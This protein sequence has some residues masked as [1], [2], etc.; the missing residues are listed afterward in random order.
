MA[1]NSLSNAEAF[2]VAPEVQMGVQL[3]IQKGWDRSLC[4]ETYL[5]ALTSSEALQHYF[6]VLGSCVAVSFDG[7]LR[8][9]LNDVRERRWMAPEADDAERLADFNDWYAQL[10]TPLD[11]V[12]PDIPDAESERQTAIEIAR[13][14]LSVVYR[15]PIGRLPTAPIRPAYVYGH[16]QSYGNTEPDDVFYRYEYFPTSSRRR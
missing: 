16:M 6:L 4:K 5:R 8:E 10:R 2:V 13:S 9:Q 3:G 1:F 7:R 14:I 11:L 15:C 12:P